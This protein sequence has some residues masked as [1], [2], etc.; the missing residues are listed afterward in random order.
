MNRT[1]YRVLLGKIWENL[2]IQ[3]SDDENLVLKSKK[4]MFW[5]NADWDAKIG[6]DTSENL[7]KK[8]RRSFET[9]Q[10]AVLT[11]QTE[12]GTE[13]PIQFKHPASSAGAA[14]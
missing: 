6:V 9:P 1:A 2:K 11:A 12:K 10:S 7:T 13:P 3:S 8:F 14:V 5:K 4:R